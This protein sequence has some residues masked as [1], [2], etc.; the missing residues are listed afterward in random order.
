MSTLTLSPTLFNIFLERIMYEVLDGHEG[1]VSRRRRFIT[2]FLFADDIVVNA[3][4]E[5]ANILVDRPDTT[6]RLALTRHK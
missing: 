1:S 2:N 4:E 3:E 5:E 6:W